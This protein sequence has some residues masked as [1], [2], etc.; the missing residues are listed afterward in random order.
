M[1]QINVE[2]EGSSDNWSPPRAIVNAEYGVESSRQ[3]RIRNNKQHREY[4]DY[5][6]YNY[7]TYSSSSDIYDHGNINSDENNGND[8]VQSDRLSRQKQHARLPQMPNL[9]SISNNFNNDSNSND[10]QNK[11]R[12]NSIDE[13]KHDHYWWYRYHWLGNRIN[14]AIK[15]R[16]VIENPSKNNS[17]DNDNSNSNDCDTIVLEEG[18]CGII[19]QD[20]DGYFS[21]SFAGTNFNVLIDPD[22]LE[23]SLVYLYYPL[24]LRSTFKHNHLKIQCI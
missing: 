10:K 12:E 2:D 4:T 14:V 23:D 20:S 13:P 7:S 3:N 21:V 11:D 1:F 9:E 19:K 17:N 22:N 18:T 8:N 16:T 6:N 5:R 15:H 24:Q